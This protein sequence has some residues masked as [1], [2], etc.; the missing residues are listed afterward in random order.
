MLNMFSLPIVI[1]SFRL[2]IKHSFFFFGQSF[3]W[4]FLSQVTTI[5]CLVSKIGPS[6]LNITCG[7]KTLSAQLHHSA[8]CLQWMSGSWVG[9]FRDQI[10]VSP[11]FLCVSIGHN[12]GLYVSRC[13]T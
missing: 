12:L 11:I 10:W 1:P 8:Y 4:V 3:F 5:F 2:T 6:P 13:G 9:S 7:P